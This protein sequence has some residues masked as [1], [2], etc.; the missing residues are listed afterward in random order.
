MPARGSADV[1]AVPLAT[2]SCGLATAKPPKAERAR[3]VLQGLG[4]ACDDTPAKPNE[5]ERATD[6]EEARR[7][8]RGSVRR[9]TRTRRT[10]EPGTLTAAT[11]P[12]RAP[13]GGFGEA[14][15]SGA[16]RGDRTTGATTSAATK[17]RR[18]ADEA[19]GAARGDGARRGDREKEGKRKG[20]RRLFTGE[21]R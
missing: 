10:D 6:S 12:R 14:T 16:R 21:T 13:D 18:A 9:S 1:S 8:E 19:L 7:R 4:G 5:P 3:W 11:K 17:P 20:E 2:S 15:P